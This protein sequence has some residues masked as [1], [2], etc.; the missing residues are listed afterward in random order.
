MKKLINKKH[1]AKIE[2]RSSGEVFYGFKLSVVPRHLLSCSIDRHY[3]SSLWSSVSFIANEHTLTVD[4]EVII[5]PNIERQ[6]NSFIEKIPKEEFSADLLMRKVS[7]FLE[8]V[9]DETIIVDFHS[10]L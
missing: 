9:F 1:A 5:R 2:K 6:E 7:E 4:V 8:Q 10:I 3:P